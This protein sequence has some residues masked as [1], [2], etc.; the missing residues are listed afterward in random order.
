MGLMAKRNMCRI[1]LKRGSLFLFFSFL[2]F[3][4]KLLDH[5][6]CKVCA[7]LGMLGAF[8]GATKFFPPPPYYFVPTPPTAFSA[9]QAISFRLANQVSSC[10]PMLPCIRS[11]H[12]PPPPF[13][14]GCVEALSYAR[15]LLLCFVW[16]IWGCMEGGVWG[17]AWCIHTACSHN[18]FESRQ[19][20]KNYI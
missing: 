15:F 5:M 1:Q 16:L 18:R 12:S 14:L 13:V 11:S 4:K 20:K 7:Q 17:E 9:S 2:F 6:Y 19:Q 3:L 8:G 10:V